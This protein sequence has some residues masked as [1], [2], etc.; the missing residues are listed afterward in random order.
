MKRILSS[1]LIAS[2]PFGSTLAQTPAADK[3]A[4]VTLVAEH[5]LPN[6]PG[7]SLRAV[8]VEYDPGAGSPSHRH[9]PSAFIYARVLEG[10]IRSKVNDAPERT[11]QVGES[12]TE[13][14]GDHHLVSQNASTTAPAKLLAV[15]IAG[16]VVMRSAGCVINDFADR[17]IDPHVKRTRT[18]PLAARRVSPP[19]KSSRYAR[20]SARMLSAGSPR[21]FSPIRFSPYR[22]ARSP[23]TVQ[24][25]GASFETIAPAAHSADS[26][27]R[28]N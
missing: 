10:A 21:R 17:N 25:G 19:W 15:F 4:K 7:K 6:V 12:W 9:P 1:L 22:R 24:N 11:Y 2:L 5:E 23:A 16:T 3:V 28:T 18:R 20:F 27:T 13:K 14:P 8:L 26:P